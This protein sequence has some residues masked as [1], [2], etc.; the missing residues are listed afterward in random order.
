M[1]KK[2]VYSLY[3]NKE[4]TQESISNQKLLLLILLTG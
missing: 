4:F 1:A 3:K 2:K